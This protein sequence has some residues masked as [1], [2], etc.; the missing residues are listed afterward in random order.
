MSED[1]A[2]IQNYSSVVG[3]VRMKNIEKVNNEFERLTTIMFPLWSKSRYTMN[4]AAFMHEIE[5]LREY[6]FAEI[7]SLAACYGIN[8]IN[9]LNAYTGY[10]MIIQHKHGRYKLYSELCPSFVRF[11]SRIEFLRGMLRDLRTKYVRTQTND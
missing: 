8:D 2:N 6:T 5:P 9:D 11:F 4:I 1:N 7:T 3:T 10:G